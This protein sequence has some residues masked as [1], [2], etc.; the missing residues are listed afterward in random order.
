MQTETF[1]RGL[2]T[3]TNALGFI[4]GAEVGTDDVRQETPAFSPGQIVQLRT[5]SARP[6]S[7]PISVVS[8][9]PDGRVVLFDAIT[10][11]SYDLQPGQTIEA[12]ILQVRPNFY[13]AQPLSVV[14][15][16]L[17]DTNVNPPLLEEDDSP[18]GNS[19]SSYVLRE[20]LVTLRS[21]S[22]SVEVSTSTAA[23]TLH[24]PSDCDLGRAV[25]LVLAFDNG[26][27]RGH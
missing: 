21:K 27:G 20:R 2:P 3:P 24:N 12:K 23:L 25:R 9:D 6:G 15:R 17:T 10:P 1:A 7:G 4:S 5:R 8:S 26:G 11:L 16:P 13:F 18:I 22:N 19:D 14:A